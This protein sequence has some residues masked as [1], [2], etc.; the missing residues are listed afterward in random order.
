MTYAS[1]VE[2]GEAADE[3]SPMLRSSSSAAKPDSAHS[4]FGTVLHFFGGG[5]YAPDAATYDPIEI[6]LNTEDQKEKDELTVRWRDN[7]LSEL[8]FIGV[9]AALLAGVLTSTGSWPQV[10][11]SGR[12]SPWPIRTA[13][14]CGIILSLFSILTAADQ[15]V[16]LHRLSAHRDGLDGIRRLLA[17]T[18]GERKHS[19]KTG[20]RAPSLLQVFTWQMPVMFLTTATISMIIGMFLHVW[21][22]T[23]H[24]HSSEWWD[25]NSK[26]RAPFLPSCLSLRLIPFQVALTFTV[27]ALTSIILFFAGQVS[28]YTP[29]Q[30]RE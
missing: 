10:L 24:L 2:G 11:P 14:Y 18:N 21:S 3:R 17:K 28:L 9:V 1:D 22:A 26:V 13:W 25:D 29:E 30:R 15:T 27:V 8:S 16:R 4:Y 7:K 5:I 6:L 19:K 23:R 12:E 20:R